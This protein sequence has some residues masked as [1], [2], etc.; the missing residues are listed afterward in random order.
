[1]VLGGKKVKTTKPRVRSMDGHEVALESYERFQSRRNQTEFAGKAGKRRCRPFAAIKKCQAPSPAIGHWHRPAAISKT[2]CTGDGNHPN[3]RRTI[4][5]GY[6]LAPT[7]AWWLS[8]VIEADADDAGDSVASRLRRAKVKRAE[9]EAEIRELEAAERRARLMSVTEVQ[10]GNEAR[11]KALRCE[12]RRVQRELPR[13]L[14]G[15]ELGDC[16]RIITR[17]FDAMLERFMK[18]T[19]RGRPRRK[20]TR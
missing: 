13:A 7:T 1:M 3:L 9:A 2:M 12:T 14:A 4:R 20:R 10:Q 6:P 16:R 15:H 5:I 19:P 17:H 18:A 11:A 8:N